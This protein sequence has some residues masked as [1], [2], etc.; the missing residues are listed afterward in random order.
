[1]FT[2]DLFAESHYRVSEAAKLLGVSRWTVYYRIETGK[3]PAVWLADR[4]LIPREDFH[5][6]YPDKAPRT[7]ETASLGRGVCPSG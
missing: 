5:R 2:P 6:L 7:G 1:M 4:W 3:I